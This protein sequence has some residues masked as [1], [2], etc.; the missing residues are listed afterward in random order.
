MAISSG[1][2]KAHGLVRNLPVMAVVQTVAY[3]L[4]LLVFTVYIVGDKV[5]LIRS[6]VGI[7]LMV[8]GIWV[9]RSQ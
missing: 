1:F 3:Y 7:G 6:V 2:I 4:F 9:I 8:A 5:S